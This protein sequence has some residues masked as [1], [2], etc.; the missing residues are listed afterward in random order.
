MAHYLSSH[1]DFFM[2]RKEMHFF[3]SDL[4]FGRGFY[5]R[6]LAG[7]LREFEGWNGQLRIG[8]A[9]VWYLFSTQAA[10][11]IKA[12]NPEA[13]IL[14]MLRDPVEMLHSLYCY[15]LYDGN[16]FL[17]S[18]AEALAAEPE[19]KA[20]R[21][22]ARRSYFPQGLAYRETVRYAAQ[23]ARYY[24]VFGRERVRVVLYDDFAADPA[25]VC[26]ETVEFLGLDPARLGPHFEVVNGARSVRSPMFQAVLGDP[27][28]RSAVLALR[29]CVPGAV[30]RGLQRAEARL[31]KLNARVAPRTSLDPLLRDALRQEFAGQNA[32]LGRLIGRD[33]GAW[34]EAGAGARS[35]GGLPVWLQE[36]LAAH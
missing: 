33:L 16:E 2:G 7:Y 19:R 25:R 31:R 22:L 6:S 20:G 30:F 36:A 24:E 23:V 34:G 18:F 3:G 1:P 28:V 29:P 8:E 5:R 27:W 17:P 12:F 9:S 14:I 32:E 10:A 35:A 21:R 26:R 11:E 4:R 15:F 13:R